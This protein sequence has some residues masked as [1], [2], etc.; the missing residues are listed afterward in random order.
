MRWLIVSICLLFL[1]IFFYAI[2]NGDGGVLFDSGFYHHLV[3][4]TPFWTGYFKFMTFWANTL[5][6]IIL[7]AV[8][9][10]TLI[11]KKKWAIYLN[12]LMICSTLINQILKHLVARPRPELALIKESGYSFPS[13]HTMGAVS[14]YGF[15]IWLVANSKLSKKMKWLINSLLVFLILNISYSRVYLGV[16]Y[17]SD[18]LCGALISSAILLISTYLIKKYRK[19][20]WL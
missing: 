20:D 4:I 5:T 10:I 16:H 3:K 6:L 14:F 17:I 11:S 9:L 18:V 15:I 1:G 8:S 2:I 7:C 19:E 13:G 12:G